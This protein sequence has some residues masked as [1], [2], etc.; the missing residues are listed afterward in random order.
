MWF[1]RHEDF[2]VRE[3]EFLASERDVA[4]AMWLLHL[5][6]GDTAFVADSANEQGLAVLSFSSGES[7]GRYVGAVSRNP[8]VGAAD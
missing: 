7:V 1:L 8:V 5:A 6:G 2:I 3:P 4:D